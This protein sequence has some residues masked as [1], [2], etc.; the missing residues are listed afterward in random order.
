MM[1]SRILCL[2]AGLALVIPGVVA[3]VA[4]D[5]LTITFDVV[6][7]GLQCGDSWQEGVFS[8][9]FAFMT[10]EDYH[11]GDNYYCNFGVNPGWLYLGGVRLYVNMW[12]LAGVT[13]V[14]VDVRENFDTGATRAFLYTDGLSTLVDSM[15]SG[16]PSSQ[17]QT[18]TVT[19][20]GAG[21]YILAIS[22]YEAGLYEIRVMGATLV[23]QRTTTWG[24][25]K[26]LY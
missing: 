11:V 15:F 18:L 9:N 6:A 22:G 14:E 20:D 1:R 7:D 17:T 2:A 21:F 13:T 25:V 12:A 10:P 19:A 26:A 24:S 4:A 3:P 5:Q 23:P 8:L 16:D